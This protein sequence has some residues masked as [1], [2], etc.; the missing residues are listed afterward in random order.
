MNQLP[1]RLVLLAGFS[2]LLGAAA[3]A[4]AQDHSWRWPLYLRDD[5]SGKP[6]TGQPRPAAWNSA[7]TSVIAHEEGLALREVDRHALP[8]L[9]HELDRDLR[10]PTLSGV[11]LEPPDDDAAHE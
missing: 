6:I 1:K 7:R 9:A 2:A 5:S 4:R 10:N 8:H 11:V 3:P